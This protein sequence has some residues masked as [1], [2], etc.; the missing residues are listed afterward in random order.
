MKK[1]L[2]TRGPA[3]I[4]V[5]SVCPLGWKSEP[6][7]SQALARLGVE[8]CLWPLFEIDQG[9]FRLTFR[10]NVKRPVVEYLRRQGR[11]AHLFKP[12]NEAMLEHIQAKVDEDWARLLERERSS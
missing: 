4:N 10:P 6:E 11:F 5:L 7:E 2:E 9:K 8:T 12:G 1:A 3:F